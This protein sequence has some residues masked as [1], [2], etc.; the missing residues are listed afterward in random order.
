MRILL[1]RHLEYSVSRIYCFARYELA[2]TRLFPN[3]IKD[4]E[5]AIYNVLDPQ[6]C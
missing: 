2:L 6:R 1:G 3:T 4:N 5:A